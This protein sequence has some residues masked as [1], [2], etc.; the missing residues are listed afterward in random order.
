M[1]TTRHFWPYLAYFFLEWEVFYAKCVQE[2]T[3]HVLCSITLFFFENRTFCE[4]KLKNF[5][6]WGRP[7]MTTWRMHIAYKITKATQTHTHTQWVTQF[8]STAT[9]VVR[10]DLS[11][12]LYVHW[13]S[14]S[15][16]YGN[17]FYRHSLPRT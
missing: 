17:I 8:F 6:E 3:K 14:C 12:T 15:F 1:K 7:Q 10:N 4:V 13:L 5:E 2:I 9:M 16:R 11:V